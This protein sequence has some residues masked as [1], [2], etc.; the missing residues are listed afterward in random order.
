MFQVPFPPGATVI[1]YQ[2][3]ARERSGTLRFQSA[4]F[5]V[6][7]GQVARWP[8]SPMQGATVYVR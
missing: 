4:A 8:L 7:P 1:E 6:S 5:T 2:L 3:Q